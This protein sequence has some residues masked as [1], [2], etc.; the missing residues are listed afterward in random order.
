MF[1]HLKNIS[2]IRSSLT[3]EATEKLVHAF[4]SSRLDNCNVL[5]CGLPSTLLSKLQ[6]V[7][8]TA[9]RIVTRRAKHQ[10]I[11]SIMKEL[12]WLPI[13]QRIKFKIIALTW[14]SLHGKAP[15]Y[16]SELLTPYNPAR[17]L[18]SSHSSSL[19]I[20]RCHNNYG[21][22]AFSSAAPLLWNSLPATMKETSCY[23]TFKCKLKSHLFREAYS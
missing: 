6:R 23:V 16:I 19:V 14:K 20:P 2:A 8:H 22:R 21:E 13:K 17:E 12:H 3:K 1:Y 15:T 9:A 5:L 11:T 7:Q 4:I 10:S 18:R